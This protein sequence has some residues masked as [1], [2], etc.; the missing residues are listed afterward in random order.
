MI[1]ET[2]YK[3]IPRKSNKK[4]RVLFLKN[5]TNYWMANK[6][7][8]EYA[9]CR[10]GGN[11]AKSSWGCFVSK[12]ATDVFCISSVLVHPIHKDT[13]QDDWI[14][15]LIWT[16]PNI[17]ISYAFCLEKNKGR[18][19]YDS[20]IARSCLFLKM[21]PLELQRARFV[22]QQ[23]FLMLENSFPIRLP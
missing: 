22:F 12:S 21:N 18:R 5:K 2:L 8:H 16:K 10:N 17:F 15:G 6:Y 20:K 1:D 11:V 3:A 9:L 13:N 23:G 19:K 14:K 4:A 7:W